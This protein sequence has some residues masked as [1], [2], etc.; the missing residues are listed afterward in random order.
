MTYE[1]RFLWWDVKI[2]VG[3]KFFKSK[4]SETSY[5]DEDEE[6]KKE[7]DVILGPILSLGI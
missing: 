1:W 7:Y 3:K 2:I 5:W 4:E 6:R